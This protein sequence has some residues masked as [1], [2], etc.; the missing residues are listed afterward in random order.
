VD[1]R[2]ADISWFEKS[3]QLYPNPASDRVTVLTGRNTP[4]TVT[5]YNMNGSV[6]KTQQVTLEGSMDVSTLPH[7]VYVVKCGART[8]RLVH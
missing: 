3:L 2:Q 4:E 6:V 5:I 1:I 7:G 8:A